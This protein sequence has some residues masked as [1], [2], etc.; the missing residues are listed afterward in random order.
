MYGIIIQYL[1]PSEDSGNEL[2][3]IEYAAALALAAAGYFARAGALDAEAKYDQINDP[4]KAAVDSGPI[5]YKLQRH[6]SFTVTL[7]THESHLRHPPLVLAVSE[8]NIC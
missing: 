1:K 5:R 2:A 4:I 7:H 3:G 8:R 6:H